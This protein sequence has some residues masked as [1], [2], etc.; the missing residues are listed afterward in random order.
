M[1]AASGDISF[2]GTKLDVE[3]SAGIRSANGNVT[4]NGT[5]VSVVGQDGGAI[6]ANSGS[7]NIDSDYLFV[8][9]EGQSNETD[10]QHGVAGMQDVT[11]V[12]EDATIVGSSYGVYSENGNISLSGKIDV[13]ANEYGIYAKSGKINMSGAFTV[14]SN[15]IGIG[16]QTGLTINGAVNATSTNTCIGTVDGDIIIN[17]NITAT[18]TSSAALLNRGGNIIINGG[19]VTVQ[20]GN[21][22]SWPYGIAATGNIEIAE[23][24]TVIAKG[25]D[26]IYSE[27]GN[28]TIAGTVTALAYGKDGYG[29]HA[30]AGSI[31]ISGSATIPTSYIAI[32]A[33][34]GL[35]IN[36]P[37][38]ATSTNTCIGTV[39]GDLIINADVTATTTSSAAL[40]NRGQQSYSICVV[41][42]KH[43]PTSN[44]G[45]GTYRLSSQR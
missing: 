33:Q 37:V 27:K 6:L 13:G 43:Q 19:K 10:W 25:G 23:G 3:G 7:I 36:G 41:Y 15:S 35:T 4:I 1:I 28:I 26:A 42:S 8:Q 38:N 21:D 9:C 40:L 39:D 18:T 11:I 2:N 22:G 30:K 44:K 16:A 31:A 45:R 5:N 32:S 17:A 14:Q 12:S 29:I 34:T 24:A 20:G